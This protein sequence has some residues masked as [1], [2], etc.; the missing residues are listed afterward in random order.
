MKNARGRQSRRGFLLALLAIAVI[1]A[2]LLTW[3]TTRGNQTQAITVD[4]KAAAGTKAEGYVVGSPTAPVEIVEFADFECPGCGQ[5]ATVTEPD[6]RSRLVSTGRARFRLID[7]QVN[8]GHRNAPAASL[9]AACANDQGKFWE[10]HDRIFAGQ[11]EWNTL[12]TDDPKSVLAGYA[13]AI[14]LNETAWNQCYDARTHLPRLAAHMSEAQ[15]R[16][17]QGTPTFI[18]GDKLVNDVLAYDVLKAYVD[19]AAATAPAAAPAAPAPNAGA[20]A[21]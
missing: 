18:I 8:P 17:V 6:V 10:M 1:G 13:R 3:A 16:G 19:S 15:R 2:G 12:A 4:P 20:P 11:N 21:R 7:I 14:G 5:F 9:A